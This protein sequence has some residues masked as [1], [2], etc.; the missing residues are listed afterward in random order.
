MERIIK[1]GNLKDMFFYIGIEHYSSKHS[2]I[3][4]HTHTHTHTYMKNL[5]GWGEIEFIFN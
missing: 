1:I 5:G 4:T 2:F 3:H